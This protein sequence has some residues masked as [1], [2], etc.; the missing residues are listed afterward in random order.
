MFRN[1]AK[2]SLKLKGEKYLEIIDVQIVLQVVKAEAMTSGEKV[3]E[4]GETSPRTKHQGREWRP[5]S[6]WVTGSRDSGRV[7]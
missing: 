4:A 2:Q 5:V 6:V 3:G 7:G 1:D